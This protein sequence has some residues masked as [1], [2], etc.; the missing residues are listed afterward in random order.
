MAAKMVRLVLLF[1]LSLVAN[2]EAQPNGLAAANQLPDNFF[3]TQLILLNLSP[4]AYL[5]HLGR[6][7][8]I[9]ALSLSPAAEP[10]GGFLLEY[11]TDEAAS[12]ALR[13][14]PLTSAMM[15][16]LM[17]G[18][19]EGGFLRSLWLRHPYSLH[20]QPRFNYMPS[21]LVKFV[22]ACVTLTELWVFGLNRS[23]LSMAT[24]AR[25]LGAAPGRLAVNG[26]RAYPPPPAPPPLLLRALPIQPAQLDSDDE[27]FY[28]GGH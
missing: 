14:P 23:D 15:K 19:R 10:D 17:R 28:A 3:Y 8:R 6:T 25:L 13:L 12:V 5:R 2:T 4:T 27:A 11:H 7:S 9:V 18:V 20:G 1:L 16:A 24:L 26:I 21:Q 22:L